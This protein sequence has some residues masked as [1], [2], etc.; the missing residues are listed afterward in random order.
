MV[1]MIMDTTMTVPY[2][3]S[4]YPPLLGNLIANASVVGLQTAEPVEEL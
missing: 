3:H 2:H 1:A 4:L